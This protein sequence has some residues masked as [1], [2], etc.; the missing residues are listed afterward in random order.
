MSDEKDGVTLIDCV[1]AGSLS[2]H[3]QNRLLA[4]LLMD[5]DDNTKDKEVIYRHK[6]GGLLQI[7]NTIY[8]D[9]GDDDFELYMIKVHGID[10]KASFIPLPAKCIRL[11]DKKGKSVHWKDID[12]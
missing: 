1:L 6:K 11:I 2:H 8:T 3:R 7:D 5:G 9:N 12:A 4:F 10:Q